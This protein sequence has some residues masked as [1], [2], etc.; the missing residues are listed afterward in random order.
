[1]RLLRLFATVV[2][3][4]CLVAC[5]SADDD[6]IPFASVEGY[7]A[8]TFNNAGAE[9]IRDAERWT[10]FWQSN[11][12]E[13]PTEPPIPPAIDF[14]R[15]LVV[16]LFGTAAG[17]GPVLDLVD[18]V[19][20]AGDAALVVYDQRTEPTCMMAAPAYQVIR[21]ERVSEVRFEGVPWLDGGAD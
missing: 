13:R 14:E 8:L 5:D 3:A 4:T 2:L 1:M 11:L 17:C 15:D 10:A 20:R 16:A 9:V 6:M 21:F 12:L 19:E 7:E 18:R